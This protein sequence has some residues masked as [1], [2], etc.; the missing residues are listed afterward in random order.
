MKLLALDSNSILNRAF[1]GIKLLTTKNGEYTNAV[2]GFINILLKLLDETKPD[3]VA[4]AFDLKAPTF[5]HKMYDGYKAQRKGMPEELA[6]QLPLIKELLHC[7]GYKVVSLEGYEADDI[8]GTLSKRCRDAGDECVI[9]T[10]DRDSLQLVG[11]GVTVLL[12]TTKMGRSET[13]VYDEGV[14]FEKYGVS[15]KALIEV[16]ALMGDSSDNIPGVAGVGEKTA[17]A[18]VSKFNTLEGIYLNIEDASIKKGVREKLIAD[19]DMAYLS[20]ELATINC[21]MPLS[22]ELSEYLIGE[23]DKSEAAKLLQRLEMYSII[24]KLGMDNIEIAPLKQKEAKESITIIKKEYDERVSLDSDLLFLYINSDSKEMPTDF[25]L[26]CGDVIY[27]SSDTELENYLPVIMKQSNKIVTNN[28]KPLYKFLIKKGIE[29]QKVLFD[30]SVAGYLLSASSN[31]YTPKRLFDEYGGE[32]LY[33]CEDAT[34]IYL[35]AIYETLNEQLHK[36][37]MDNLFFEIE[38]PLTIVLSDM[39]HYG[40]ELDIKGIKEYGAEIDKKIINLTQKIYEYSEG[41]FNIN[42]PKQLG[43]VLFE[44]LELPHGK[45]TK[46]GYSTNA[47]VLENLRKKHPIIDNILEYRSL[48]KLKSTYVEGLLKVVDESGRIHTNFKQTETRTGRISSTEPNMQNIPVRTELGAM[49]RKFFK[50]SEGNLLVDADYSQI[51]LRVLSSMSEDENMCQAFVDGEDIHTKTAAEVFDMPPLFITS[52]MRGRAKAVNFGI[53]Y[54]IGAFSLSKD[55]GVTVAEADKYIKGYL[56]TYEG[57]KRY[58]DETVKQGTELGYVSTVY[59]RRRY[60]P[61]LKASNKIQKAFGERVAMNMPIQGTAADIIKIAMIKVYNRLLEEKLKAKLILQIHDELIIECP[62]SEAEKVRQ[63]VEYEMQNAVKLKV[64]L[65][66]E[67]K[68]GA[69]WF[70]AK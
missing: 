52:E 3:A 29:P 58:M 19:K 17:L 4:C 22:G 49:L 53:V 68:I 37:G 57:V 31:D 67:G 7:L 28:S 16:K 61:E 9:A 34:V 64:P 1:Y 44:K 65:I 27:T 60:L 45:K 35:Q 23:C 18:L 24:K 25:E 11:D 59:G 48:A 56:R 51:E 63:L 13:I 66:A 5:R 8:L 33:K 6:A 43:D 70:E 55:I 32:L 26:L 20:R 40:F 12:A 30:T 69:N 21:D 36:T 39:E 46:T 14:I 50:A 2:Y 42:S 15:P 62:E 10:G 38:M 54:G 47:D 41:E